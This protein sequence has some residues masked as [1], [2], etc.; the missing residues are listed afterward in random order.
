MCNNY[1][2]KKLSYR[3]PIAVI[4]PRPSRL[5]TPASGLRLYVRNPDATQGL[6]VLSPQRTESAPKL[7][8]YRRNLGTGDSKFP[9]YK[10]NPRAGR[11]IVL[12]ST[13]RTIDHT[14]EYG[15]DASGGVV[16]PVATRF[17]WAIRSIETEY[18]SG[19]WRKTG[20]PVFG[21]P[22]RQ[23]SSFPFISFFFAQNSQ[24]I[25]VSHMQLIAA[26]NRCGSGPSDRIFHKYGPQNLGL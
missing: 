20:T 25:L 6:G 5:F 16:R 10:R 11:S 24:N 3:K 13:L 7:P 22:D 9:T 21:G 12:S 26:P 14:P 18:R 15:Q 19:L 23:S 8:T 4:P 17:H 1:V 2:L